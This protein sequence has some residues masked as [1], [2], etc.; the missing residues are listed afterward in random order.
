MIFD[1]KN[2]GYGP[3]LNWYKAQMANLNS[4]EK[5]TIP[6]KSLHIQQ[7]TLAILGSR[8]STCVPAM[9]EHLMRPHVRDLKVVI[10]DA[11]HWL[12]LQKSDDV[13]KIIKEFLEEVDQKSHL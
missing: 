13:N 4:Q 5:Y 3:A 12:Q 1:P 7:R 6:L 11:G 10:V 9:Q 8:D 2:G